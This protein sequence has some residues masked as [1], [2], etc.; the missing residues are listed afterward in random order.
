M[1]ALLLFSLLLLTL[2]AP[3]TAADRLLAVASD[4][5]AWV[6]V[7]DK[8]GI[9]HVLHHPRA[10]AAP[11][12][13][14]LRTLPRRPEAIAAWGQELWIVFGPA[15]RR[16]DAM[17]EVYRLE[18]RL[19]PVSGRY[20]GAPADR[21][22]FAPPLPGPV[23]A[24]CGAH[25]GPVALTR[26]AEGLRLWQLGPDG[27]RSIDL[28]PAVAARRENNWRIVAA[29]AAGRRIRLLRSQGGRQ[30][31]R[32]SGVWLD[33]PGPER[34]VRG[35]GRVEGRVLATLQAGPAIEIA[36]LAGDQ[37][38]P[39]A[40][41]PEP[42]S[43]WAVVG[44]ADGPRLI[45]GP[46]TESLA[47]QRVDP[48]VGTPTPAAD[49]RPTP[50]DAMTVMRLPV[51]MAI[52]LFAVAM[53]AVLRPAG[54][55]PLP[56]PAETALA[57]PV[58]RL[59]AVLI[60]MA[61]AALLVLFVTG[62]RPP[63]LLGLP[64]MT[65][66]FDESVPYIATAG[67]TIVHAGAG[68]LFAGRTLGKLV[69]GLRVIHVGGGRPPSSLIVLRN[70]MKLV[71]VLVPPLAVVALTNPN[72]QG[73]DDLVGRTLVVRKSCPTDVTPGDR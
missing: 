46:D 73:L 45:F 1:P 60:D 72:W 27:W 36:Y 35:L 29:G 39:L 2:T 15:D 38:L 48:V 41:M 47:I 25:D 26:A 50:I 30:W 64:L 58:L 71:V 24:M 53:V 17:R 57:P 5:H 16:T 6:V 61:P 11:H 3:A 49:L 21:L 12:V 59:A 31:E 33:R 8:A 70:A 68:E 32:Q 18:V 42:A 4:E 62:G 14:D 13:N 19:N 55:A 20:Y 66:T 23:L 34:P 51:L 37:V 10:A 43:A 54:R 69:L 44:L 22:A 65:R 7:A 9:M 56:L 63:D 67:L 52:A 40:T 28:P